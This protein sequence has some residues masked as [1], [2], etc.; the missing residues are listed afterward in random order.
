M[1]IFSQIG[2]RSL[3]LDSGIEPGLFGGRAGAL[4]LSYGMGGCVPL[5]IAGDK[6]LSSEL[7]F[8]LPTR[9]DDVIFCIYV[10]KWWYREYKGVALPKSLICCEPRHLANLKAH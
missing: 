1:E 8:D 6:K 4:P 2:R 9:R 7:G 10:A 5:P 3:L